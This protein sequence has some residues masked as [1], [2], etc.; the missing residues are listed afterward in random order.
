MTESPHTNTEDRFFLPDL[1]NS[2]SVF[3]L[4]LVTELFAIV[5]ELVSYDARY[6]NWQ[7]FGLSSLFIQWVSLSSAA[8]LC[9]LRKP[10]RELPRAWAASICL[11]IVLGN[12]LVFSLSTRWLTNYWTPSFHNLDLWTADILINVLVAGI[13]GGLVLRYFYIQEQL[14]LKAESELQARIQAL[15]SRIRPHFLFNSMNIIASLISIDPDTAETVVED[16]SE[17]FRASLNN[18][19]QTLTTIKE[20]LDLCQRYARIEQLRIGDR[21][22]MDWRIDDKALK[23]KIPMLSIQPLLENA[24]YHGIQ[25]LPEGG[26]VIV[27]IQLDEEAISVT[28][29]NPVLS[30]TKKI[31]N[32]HIGNRVALDNIRYRLDALYGEQAKLNIELKDNQYNVNLRYPV[33]VTQRGQQL[34]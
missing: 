8:F 1:C 26:T 30:N 9:Y 5:I 18:Q 27:E 21:L 25:P 34:T 14:Q 23:H 15:Q 31:Q 7:G 32:N 10:L 3:I 16:L 19:T 6:L 28:L 22:L 4:V 24:I 33:S 2:Q 11:G 13:I 20:E 17:L 29:I 12:T